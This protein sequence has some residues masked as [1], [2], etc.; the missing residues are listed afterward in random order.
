MQVQQPVGPRAL[1][2]A[3]HHAASGFAPLTAPQT[4]STFPGTAYGTR[5]GVTLSLHHDVVEA[6]VVGFPLLV[7]DAARPIRCSSRFAQRR[8][9]SVN[10]TPRAILAA[11]QIKGEGHLRVRDAAH[12]RGLWPDTAQ[13]SS[14]PCARRSAPLRH[15]TCCT[16]RP[17]CPRRA[18]EAHAPHPAQ[19]RGRRDG[20]KRDGRFFDVKQPAQ[21]RPTTSSL[22]ASHYVK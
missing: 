6:A 3:I 9:Q 4:S 5:G 16:S 8:L 10:G 7:R 17:T 20:R 14:Q 18:A 22:R 15:R 19:D 2:I 13:S 1:L 12:G 11:M 21:M